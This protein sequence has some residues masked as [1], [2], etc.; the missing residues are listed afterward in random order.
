MPRM[1]KTVSTGACQRAAAPPAP[2]LPGHA[3]P[4]PGPLKGAVIPGRS[5]N[6]LGNRFVYAV[7]SQRA[8]GLSVGINMSPDQHCNF[9]CVYCEIPRRPATGEREV[10]LAALTSE[11]RRMLDL[12]QTGQLRELAGYQSLPR[13]LLDLKEVALSGDGE[14]TLSPAFAE[15]V[16]A[17]AHLRAQQTFPYYKIV[18]I[19]NAT[20][21]HLPHVQA[22]LRLLTPEDE[23]WAKLD[24]GTQEYLN[25][26]NRPKHG[27]KSAS[28]SLVQVMDNILA[29]GRQRPVVIQSLFPLLNGEE[30]PA[31][32]I[33]E[34][35]LRLRE[36]KE[37]NA[38]ISLV[39]VYSA[40]RT[41]VQADCGHLPLKCL[42]RI[43]QRVRD[44]TGLRAEVF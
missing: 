16:Q 40:H 20:G 27:A 6:F 3:A 19:T 37:G 34:Y 8:R 38:Q 12:V 41:A 13:E 22:G 9:D 23:I 29:L 35:V 10:Q 1:E 17:V 32:E 43:A 24:A 18:L 15:V 31:E 30:P 44:V 21:L 4:G 2:E 25:K 39:Q 14:P 5:R 26:I 11:L 42:S 28:P 36:L 33:E 7:I